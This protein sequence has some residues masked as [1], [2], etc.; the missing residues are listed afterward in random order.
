M[1]M[2]FARWQAIIIL[3]AAGAGAVMTESA[4]QTKPAQ[5]GAAFPTKPV[6]I[7]VPYS[8]GGGL[9]FIARMV[10]QPLNERWGVPIIVDNR[11]G[12]SGIVGTQIVAKA[13]PDGYTLAMVSVEFIT[14]PLVYKQ[15]P[16]DTIKDFTGVVQTASQSYLLVVH[17]SVPAQSVRELV[18]LSKTR[19]LNYT[20]SGLGGMGHLSGELLKRMTGMQM[21]YVNYKGTGP[22]LADTLAGQVHVMVVNPLPA[23]PHIK[24]GRLRLLASTDSKRIASMPDVPTIAESGVRGFSTNG[25][26]G[27]IVPA[28]TPRNVVRTINEAVA[29]IIKSPYGSERILVGG[30]EPAGGT[31][32]E[33]SAMMRADHQR[34]SEIIRTMKIDGE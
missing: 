17:P 25:W 9:D 8:P 24:S 32:E 14:A 6:R 20:S 10:S 15:F 16:Y 29:A 5:S 1:N 27:M 7:V 13:A 22:A 34:W 4:A 30:A 11:P 28:G 21:L 26:N 33:L 18:A 12:A 19:P 2:K 3:F 23:V 31:P